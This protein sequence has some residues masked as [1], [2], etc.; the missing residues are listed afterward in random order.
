[1]LSR[2]IDAP[3]AMILL[4]VLLSRAQRIAVR[5]PGASGVESLG[6]VHQVGK[7]AR[8]ISEK[9]AARGRIH[10]ELAHEIG[11]PLGVLEVLACKLRDGSIE[12]ERQADAHASM[13]R[14]AGQLR[15]LVRSVL[16]Q[17]QEPVASDP[18][19]LADLIENARREVED[20]HGS[21][22]VVVHPL[23][24]LP[25]LPIGSERLGRVLVNLLDNAIE[26]VDD[27]RPVELR[28]L[29]VNHTLHLEVRDEG[30][31]IPGEHLHRVMDP[32]VSFRH[33]GSGLG[34][35]I[36]RKIVAELGGSL[37]IESESGWGTIA[38]V[39]IQF[40]EAEAAA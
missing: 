15:E 18:V 2:T 4:A 16:E 40:A 22:R 34:L 14:L 3:L 13:A 8:F 31:G 23:P 19:H 6:D 36:S 30:A 9:F 21:G 26:A 39:R 29:C 32:F 33:G 38:R 11:K 1:M 10:A 24:R 28:V 5:V 37:E 12:P 7:E 17:D 20:V 35:W 25:H 27:L